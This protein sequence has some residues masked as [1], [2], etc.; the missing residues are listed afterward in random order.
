MVKEGHE[1][2]ACAD[3]ENVEVASSLKKI[4]VTYRSIRIER[5]GL[6]PLKDLRTL[7]R[8]YSFLKKTNP[9]AVLSYTIKPVIFGSLAAY[10]AGASNI[11]SII[12]GLGYVFTGETLKHRAIRFLA[13][14]M[15]RLALTVN[16]TVF[17]QNPDDLAFFADSGL[18]SP[19]KQLLVNGSGVDLDHFGKSD[20]TNQPVFLLIARLLKDKGI[21]EYVNAARILKKRYP[22][23]I[24]RL[25]GPL[26]SNPSAIN[27]LQ[28][29]KWQKEGMIEYLGETRDVRS[30]IAESSVYVLPSYREGTPRTVLEAMAMGRPIVT[31]DAP[32]CRETVI[33]GENGFLVPVKNVDALVQAMERF[34]LQAEL[35]GRMG[36]RSREIAE[37]K[38]DVH[39]VNE[40]ILKTMGLFKPS[41][42][43]L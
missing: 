3:G 26:D 11:Y 18:V 9:E 21:I 10:L 17:F 22:A 37:E 31:T 6:N 23:A 27:K 43:R 16:K 36:V 35:V 20:I 19:H 40:V 7:W 30:Y 28:I 4:G 12:T 41:V 42:V 38:Y 29:E 15:Y 24:F 39:K 2:I 14:N 34:I 5:A 1:V 33:D 13:A 32:G 25:L 8:L